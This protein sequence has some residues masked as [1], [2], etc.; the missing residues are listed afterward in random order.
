MAAHRSQAH[1]ASRRAHTDRHAD[2]PDGPYARS[3]RAPDT[4]AFPQLAC[5]SIQRDESPQTMSP[6]RSPPGTGRP[7][8]NSGFI[9]LDGLA[10]RLLV[11]ASSPP[12]PPTAP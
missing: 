3:A 4:P 2:P 7:R 9:D 6:T 12:P 11:G 10:H 1:K 8:S 5:F